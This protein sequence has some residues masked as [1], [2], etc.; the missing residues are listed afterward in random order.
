MTIS[1][2]SISLK[3]GVAILPNRMVYVSSAHGD[4]T[5]IPTPFT[6]VPGQ[7]EQV[8]PIGVTDGSVSKVDGV[9]HALAGETVT[10]QRNIVVTLTAGNT[11]AA[12][13]FIES[14]TDG[15]AESRMPPFASLQT[16]RFAFYQALE[17]AASG[18]KFQA[19]K[20][21]SSAY[22]VQLTS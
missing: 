22:R 1:D 13:D 3:A 18:Q 10:L 4:F 9:Y 20:I 21:G 5:V 16:F 19:I 6:D 15:I 12:G 17:P 7:S 8:I 14:S 11:I 2:N